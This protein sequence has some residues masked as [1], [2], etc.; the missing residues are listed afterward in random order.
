ML[1]PTLDLYVP[2][3]ILG[4]CV[5]S[6]LSRL[7]CSVSIDIDTLACYA[8]IHG[9]G[10]SVSSPGSSPTEGQGQGIADTVYSHALPRFLDMF[11][12][13]GIQATL[14]VI[15]QDVVQ[16][17]QAEI[18]RDAARRGHELANHSY[19]HYYHLTRLPEEEIRQEIAWGT[20]AIS[21]LLPEG[22]HVVGFRCP[23]YNVSPAVLKVLREQ[24][25]LYDSSVFPCPPYYL[26][27]ASMLAYLALRGR[28]SHSIMGDPQVLWAP[29]RPYRAGLDPHRSASV[30]SASSSL[31][32]LWELPMSVVPGIRWP[33][34]GTFLLWYPRWMLSSVNQLMM[35]NHAFLNLELHAIDMM[36]P[37]DPGAAALLPHQP[38][39]RVSLDEKLDR[40]HQTFRQ[41]SKRYEFLTLADAVRTWS[42]RTEKEGI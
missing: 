1:I 38:D 15:G 22:Q 37:E 6:R 41:L 13:Y 36:A 14:F 39:L 17:E 21:Q 24:Q 12:S 4:E 42:G 9:L 35:R 19:H 28:K 40:F 26:A 7:I 18:L 27:K 2:L 31:P 3:I 34:I 10:S 23:G 11:A 33:W 30:A 29:N 20:Q 25:Y 5:L 32:E 8:Q 16:P